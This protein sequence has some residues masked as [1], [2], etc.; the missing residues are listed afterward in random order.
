MN[1][2]QQFRDLASGVRRRPGMYF[3]ASGSGAIPEGVKYMVQGIRVFTPTKAGALLTLSVK[4]GSLIFEFRDFFQ[5]T[6]PV[7][8]V[9]Q[10]LQTLMDQK[11]W[12]LAMGFGL[13]QRF[14]IHVADGNQI[15]TLAFAD[16]AG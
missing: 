11:S 14:E 3:G 6:F 15:A 12:M 13:C 4:A 9:E 7:T 16:T 1:G 8:D 5:T 10:W 2:E